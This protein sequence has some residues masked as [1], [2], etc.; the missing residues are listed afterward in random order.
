MRATRQ[1][2]AEFWQVKPKGVNFQTLYD[3][4]YNPTGRINLQKHMT[5]KMYGL[6]T[7][8]IWSMFGGGGGLVNRSIDFQKKEHIC[9]IFF[10]LWLRYA[11]LIKYP[12]WNE[13]TQG[14]SPAS[15]RSSE[16]FYVNPS[17]TH[18]ACTVVTSCWKHFISVLTHMQH[19]QTQSGPDLL[20]QP[21]PRREA[22]EAHLSII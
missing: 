14:I 21:L 19:T 1:N 3:N 8:M 16:Y 11:L 18:Y 13:N 15:C 22:Q 10:Q 17:K 7:D 9:F 20:P 2:L 6:Q 12:E 4:V 5:R